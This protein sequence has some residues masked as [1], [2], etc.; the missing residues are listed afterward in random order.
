MAVARRL[1]L[2]VLAAELPA[3]AEAINLDEANDALSQSGRRFRAVWNEVGP[4]PDADAL[5]RGLLACQF[6][7]DGFTEEYDSGLLARTTTGAVATTSSALSGGHSGLPPFI[8]ASKIM[9]SARGLALA[10]HGVTDAA[11]RRSRMAFAIIIGLAAIAGG[12]LGVAIA[13]EGTQPVL[14]SFGFAVVF[15]IWVVGLWRAPKHRR[16]GWFKRY[17]RYLGLTLAVVIGCAVVSLIPW[18]IGTLLDPC[19][20]RGDKVTD[21]FRG[22]VEAFIT[23]LEPAFVVLALVLGAMVFG[24]KAVAP[25]SQDA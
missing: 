23:G 1:Q 7:A 24:W 11:L 22:D 3:I 16:G 25:P 17:A 20:K 9:T 13:S 10:L 2:S 4:Q 18:L 15:A 12:A 6:A 5:K 14:T 8:A 21:C 19:P